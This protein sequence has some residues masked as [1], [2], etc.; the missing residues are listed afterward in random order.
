MVSHEKGENTRVVLVLV[1][2]ISRRET[3]ESWVIPINPYSSHIL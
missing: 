2:K 3:V 1:H